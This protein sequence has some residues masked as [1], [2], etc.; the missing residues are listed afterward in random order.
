MSTREGCGEMKVSFM[1]EQVSSSEGS[2]GFEPTAVRFFRDS[3]QG[4]LGE[5]LELGK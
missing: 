1:G 3:G 4:A 2:V 5:L